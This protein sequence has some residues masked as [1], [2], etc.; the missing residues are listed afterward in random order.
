M[1][2]IFRTG[3]RCLHRK[4]LEKVNLEGGEISYGQVEKLLEQLE[5]AGETCAEIFI[6]N[7]L[8]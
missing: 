1:W 4:I 3:D 7:G 8:K 5:E 2:N 6:A